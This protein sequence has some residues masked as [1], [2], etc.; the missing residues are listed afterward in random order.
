MCRIIVVRGRIFSIST[1]TEV[2][3]VGDDVVVTQYSLLI[4]IEIGEQTPFDT[5]PLV[6]NSMPNQLL[7]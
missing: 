6:R 1:V 3:Y 2:D 5:N 4:R 7:D